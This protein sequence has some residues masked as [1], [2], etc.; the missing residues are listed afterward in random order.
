[1]AAK[2][3]DSTNSRFTL[4]RSILHIVR[5]MY[6]ITAD[7]IFWEI[8]EGENRILSRLELRKQLEQLCEHHILT[9]VTLPNDK[10]VYRMAKK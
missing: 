10:V 6:P 7:E 4:N 3:M 9:K 1:M 2:A 8:Q 5:S